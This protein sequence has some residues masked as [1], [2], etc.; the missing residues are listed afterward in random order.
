MTVSAS[1]AREELEALV[2][3]SATL[4]DGAGRPRCVI[5]NTAVDAIL[6][7]A[8]AYRR[9]APDED[10]RT[11]HLEGLAG[12]QTACRFRWQDYSARLLV[13]TG[14]PAAVTCEACRRS[15]RYRDLTGDSPEPGC[16]RG[17]RIGGRRA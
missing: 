14:N 10:G 17:P 13:L 15:R 4:L 2:R 12:A 11:V 5:G 8:D 3:R 7:L 9:A 16:H 6:A 1:E